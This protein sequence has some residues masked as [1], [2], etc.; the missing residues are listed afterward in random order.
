MSK[1]PNNSTSF[2][3]L[4]RHGA[5]RLRRLPKPPQ[6]E[7]SN[8]PILAMSLTGDARGA[9]VRDEVDGPR[10]WIRGGMMR[11]AENA[12]G[13]GR[14]RPGFREAFLGRTLSEHTRS[15][16]PRSTSI[17]SKSPRPVLECGSCMCGAWRSVACHPAG[18]TSGAD[19]GNKTQGA[20]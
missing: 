11:G 14:T 2:C 6:S 16:P 12:Q 15:A 13:K 19:P 3:K 4:N 20:S 18:C 9:A 17:R 8:V 10:I 5:R 7:S 1:R